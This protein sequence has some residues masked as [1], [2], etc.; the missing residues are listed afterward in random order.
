MVVVAGCIQPLMIPSL[1]ALEARVV[2]MILVHP[3]EH[4]MIL[5]GHLD[6]HPAV[7]VGLVEAALVDL[8]VDLE[9]DSA[10]T[11]SRCAMVENK[12]AT[13]FDDL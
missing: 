8:E 6:P 13:K 5:R 2:V 3:L 12:I 1:E 4:A 10:A 7:A 11:S 9:V